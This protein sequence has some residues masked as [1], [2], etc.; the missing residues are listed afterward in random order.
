MARRKLSYKS[1][2]AFRQGMFYGWNK[3]KAALRKHKSTK[4]K[5]R[6]FKKSKRKYT[7][8]TKVYRLMRRP[9]KVTYTAAPATYNLTDIGSYI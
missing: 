2:K 7:S 6:K 9:K 1:K 5:K 4:H 8:G 3:H